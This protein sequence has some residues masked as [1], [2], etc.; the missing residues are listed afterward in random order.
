MKILWIVNTVFPY[1]ASKIKRNPTVF[2][3]WLNSLKEELVNNNDIELAIATTYSNKN[4]EKYTDGQTI[5]YLI[6]D[7]NP[8]IYN[9]KLENY[10]KLINDDFK[11]DVVHI[12]GSEY[13]RGLSFTRT[14]EVNKKIVLSIQ[15]LIGPCSRVL[16]ANLPFVNIFRNLTIRDLLKPNTGLF[17]SRSYKKRK[18]Y[19]KEF[20]QN[21]DYIVG[22]TEWDYANSKAINPKIKYFKINEILRNPFYHEQ[23]D[24]EKIDE[25]TIF[26]SQAQQPLKGFHHLIEAIKIVKEKYPEI[27]VRIAGNN[28]F[29]TKSIIKKFKLQSYTKYLIKKTKKYDLVNNIKFIGFLTEKEMVQE[30]LKANIYVQASSMENSSNSLCEAM[31][32]GLPCIASF[33]GGTNSILK[34]EREGLLYPFTESEMLAN[35][36]IKL[37]EN[38]KLA[39]Q[40][41][42]AARKRSLIRHDKNKIIADTIS[43]YKTICGDKE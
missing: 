20:I 6:P 31:I 21:I 24:I 2:G 1:P 23:W 41:G 11:P 16:Y 40:Y 17:L 27:K 9:N 38:K 8:L 28:I 12:H 37:F 14:S 5:Y 15:G 3:G 19:E 4:Y 42:K 30:L 43:M 25:H 10:W 33:V 22:R 29:D 32:L 13:P 34:H 39:T 36:I 26:F 18:L 7:R 35:Y